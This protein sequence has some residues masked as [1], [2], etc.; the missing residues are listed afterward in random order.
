MIG[1]SG[2]FKGKL[3]KQT[4]GLLERFEKRRNA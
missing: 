3:Q 4:N 2:F 1:W